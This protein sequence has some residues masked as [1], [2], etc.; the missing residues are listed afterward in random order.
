MAFQGTYSTPKVVIADFYKKINI[1]KYYL[2]ILKNSNAD[3]LRD[4]LR[5]L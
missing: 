3:L 2:E 4:A 1:I 5:N